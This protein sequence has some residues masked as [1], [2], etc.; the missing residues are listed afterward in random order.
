[1]LLPPRLFAGYVFLTQ[2]MLLVA[3]TMQARSVDVMGSRLFVI[4]VLSADGAAVRSFGDMP[5]PATAALTDTA[6]DVVIVPAQ[7]APE[8]TL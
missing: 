3:G 6:Y 4:D 5:V 1:I 8:A 7:F 2:E